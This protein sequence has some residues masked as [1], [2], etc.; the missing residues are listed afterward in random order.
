MAFGA[1]DH[2]MNF[3]TAK[4]VTIGGGL[5]LLAGIMASIGPASAQQQQQPAPQPQ[6]KPSKARPKAT[7]PAVPA[8]PPP[9]VVPFRS[10]ESLSYRVLFSKFAVNAAQIDLS[11]VE[12]RN[13]F[14]HPAWHFR[15]AAHTLDTTRVIFPLDD[16]FDSYSSVTTLASLQYEL[17]LHEQGKQQ[18]SLYRMTTDLEPAPPDVTALRAAPGTHDAISFLYT[19]RTADW[20][21]T[22]ELRAPVFDGRRLYDAVARIDMPQ[23]TVTVPAGNF[24]ASRIAIRLFD[25]GTEM[26]DTR[27][28]LWIAKNAAH[29]PVL[30]EADIPFGTARIELLHAP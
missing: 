21:H 13:F 15:A 10:G 26:T 16:Q 22:P 9:L 30:I 2:L 29:T 20:Q 8:P 18:T 5:L 7:K 14:G 23:G 24:D 11:V 12:Q 19:L 6:K 1:P 28:W 27:F 25:H 17:Y 3:T 4:R